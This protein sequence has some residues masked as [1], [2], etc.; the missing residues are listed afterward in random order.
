MQSQLKLED[1]RRLLLDAAQAWQ[2]KDCQCLGLDAATGRIL[3]EDV[4]A[5]INVPPADNSAM[6]GYALAA[7]DGVKGA[8]LAVSQTIAAGSVPRP[9]QPATAARILTGAEMPPGADCVIIQENVTLQTEGAGD[10][11]TLNTDVQAGSNIRPRGQDI[12][13]GSKVLS[14]GDKL[15][16]EHMGLLASMGVADVSVFKPLKVALLSTGDELVEP[17]T[18]LSTGQIYNSNQPMLAALLRGMGCEVVLQQRVE[19]DHTATVNALRQASDIADVIIS[20]GGVSVGD[21]DHVKAAVQSLGELDLWK[22]AMKPG[23]PLAFG[24]VAQTP[25]IGLPGNPVSAWVTFQLMVR[26]ALTVMAGGRAS[27][28]LS[29]KLDA[30]FERTKAGGRD[31]YARGRMVDGG[32]ALFSQQSSGALSSVAWADCLVLLPAGETIRKGQPVAVLP[33]AQWRG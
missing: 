20:C 9:L 33:L 15:A 21:E 11:I 18:E 1:A 7:T 4:V 6:D 16:A 29:I 10:C 22:V 24:C 19:D 8:T 32:V 13:K 27:E 28:L 17:G 25:F 5:N 23:K 2:K 3:A 26:S 12:S 14:R 31:E 30:Q